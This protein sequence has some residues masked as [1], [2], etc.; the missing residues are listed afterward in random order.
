MLG[1]WFSR[2]L[3]RAG[4]SAGRGVTPHALRHTFSV[5]SLAMMAEQGKD[6]Y[7]I[8]CTLPIL[9]TYLGHKAIESTNHYVRLVSSMYPGLLKD[10][11]KICIN[12]F[13]IPPAMKPLTFRNTCQGF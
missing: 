3:T 10:V 8:Y 2:L 13:Q 12:V 4:I 7:C 9:A 5:Q 1:K 6:I 11:D